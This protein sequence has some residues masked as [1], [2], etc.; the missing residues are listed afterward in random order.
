MAEKIKVRIRLRHDREHVV[1][2]PCGRVI[3]IR[4]TRS[5]GRYSIE[6]ETANGG[7]IRVTTGRPGRPAS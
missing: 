5:N 4:P 6:I 7:R 3:A 1:A 2:L